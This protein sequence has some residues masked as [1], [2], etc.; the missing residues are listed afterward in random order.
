MSYFLYF[1][2]FSLNYYYQYYFF[3]FFRLL[4]SLL[5]LRLYICRKTRDIRDAGEM[6]ASARRPLRDTAGP[7]AGPSRREP[8]QQALKRISKPTALTR[9]V[10][11]HPIILP[12]CGLLLFFSFYPK[13]AQ[14]K[15]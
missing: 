12:Y 11:V 13:D 10:C 14:E 1:V 9:P 3:F 15:F 7:L 2:L 4:V 8:V 6:M 5:L